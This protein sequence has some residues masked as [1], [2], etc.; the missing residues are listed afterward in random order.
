[1]HVGTFATAV[2]LHLPPSATAWFVAARSPSDSIL[3]PVVIAGS[4]RPASSSCRLRGGNA[5]TPAAL[6][7]HCAMTL[8]RSTSE[9][10]P[11][12]PFF[13][14]FLL[15]RLHTYLVAADSNQPVC[16]DKHHPNEKQH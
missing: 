10:P 13:V 3:R 15:K 14:S 4:G 7:R 8:A 2:A 5:Y 9:D 16:E 1:M 6:R 12:K 11:R